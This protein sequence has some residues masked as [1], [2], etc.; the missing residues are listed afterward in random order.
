MSFVAALARARKDYKKIK[1]IVDTAYGEK[2]IKKNGY[3]HYSKKVKADKMSHLNSKN[4]IRTLVLIKDKCCLSVETAAHGGPEKTI[5]NINHKELGLQEQTIRWV[6]K[7]LSG[8][9]KHKQI[10]ICSDFITAMHFL[11]AGLYHYN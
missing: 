7:L 8:D 1:S 9:Q 3:L 2:S 10:R 6:A 5:F 11:T 4:P